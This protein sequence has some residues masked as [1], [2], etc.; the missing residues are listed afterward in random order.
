MSIQFKENLCI[1]FIFQETNHCSQMNNPKK[2]KY[3]D[4]LMKNELKEIK[5]ICY[6]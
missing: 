6:D 2:T 4:Y 1:K 3:L 5:M